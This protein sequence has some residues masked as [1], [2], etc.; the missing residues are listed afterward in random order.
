[1]DDKLE[2]ILNN[3]LDTRDITIYMDMVNQVKEKYLIIVSVKD[4]FGSHIPAEALEK[5]KD[6]GF[7]NIST[8]LHIMYVGV[9]DSGRVLFDKCS[10]RPDDS[11]IYNE[12]INRGG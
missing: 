3:L 7:K 2:S 8:S 12:N 1:M 5:I 9:M 10:E 11:I 4:T 6:L